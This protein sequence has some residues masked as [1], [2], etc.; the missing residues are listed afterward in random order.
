MGRLFFSSGQA[1]REL[2]ASQS[3]ILALCESGAVETE[4]TPGGQ[5]RIPAAEVQRLKRDGLP[6]L[7]R[8]LPNENDVAMRDARGRQGLPKLLAAPSSAVVESFE[9]VARKEALKKERELDWE[10]LE[11]EDRFKQREKADQQARAELEEAERSRQ[12]Q[13]D[14]QQRR[15]ERDNAWLAYA[16]IS[17]PF[18]ARGSVEVDNKVASVG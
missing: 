6:P 11:V 3:L 7:P 14:A 16:L 4:T 15:H 2:G 9:G 18:D 10:L 5:W 8:P 12:L 1:A 13:A 17:I